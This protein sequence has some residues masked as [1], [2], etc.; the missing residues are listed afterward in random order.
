MATVKATQFKKGFVPWNYGLIGVQVSTRKGKKLKP[1]SSGHKEKISKAVSKENHPMWKGGKPKCLDC[2][3]ELSNYNN[4]KCG[5]HRGVKGIDNSKWIKDRT[6]VKIGDRFLN[7]PLQKQW[8]KEVKNRD[9]WKCVILDENCNG[10]LEAHHILPW[11]QYPE[12]RYDIKNGITLCHYHHPRKND[13]VV[14]LS[15]SFQRMVD[16]CLVS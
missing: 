2:G 5:E 14:R 7:D 11:S 10:R 4:K 3:K 8:R 1:L 16:N 6:Q 13:D 12:L 15:P 9:S